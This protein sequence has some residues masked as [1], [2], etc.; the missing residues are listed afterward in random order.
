[1][2][3][4]NQSAPIL[5]Q[6]S[7]YVGDLN[8][9]V[10][11]SSLYTLFS[12]IGSVLSAR[13]C[14]DLATRNSL[15]YGYV[16]FEDPKDAERA[17]EDLNY[18]IYH[19]R[20]IRIMWSQRDPSLR[21]SG[22]GNIF[23]KNLDKSIEQKELYDT[24]SYFG[25]ILSC[26]IA[27]DEHG[28]SKGYGF[29]HFEKEECAERAI[30]KINGMLIRDRVVFVGKF[31]PSCERKSA[32]GKL[33]FNNVY[34]KNFPPDTTDEKLKEMFS[35]F[36]EIKSCC[37]EKDAEGK[38]KGFGF[39]CFLNPDHAEQ[40]VK[41]MHGKELAGRTLY[42]NRAQ[43]KEERQ[44]ELKQRLE[45][46]RLERQSKY[47]PGVNLYVKNLDDTI[48]DERLKEA[49]CHYG[50]ITSAKVMTDPNGRS[51]GFG[52]VCFTQPE[53]AA[54][55]VT[56]MNAALVGTKPLYVALAQRKEDRRAKLIA[57]HHQR[58]TQYR[59]NPAQMLPAA[60]AHAATPSYF[61]PNA[62]PQAQRYYHPTSAVLNSQPRWNRAAAMSGGMP[63]QLGGGMQARPSIPG[64]YLGAP[65]PAAGMTANQLAA[66][67]QLRSPAAVG[68]P[69]VPSGMPAGPHIP[70]SAMMN[71]AMNQR[72][73]AARPGAPMQ[74]VM[75]PPA[76]GFPQ[77]P[78]MASVVAANPNANLR[79]VGQQVPRTM[80]QPGMGQIT[81]AAGNVRFNQTARNVT[82]QSA[83]TPGSN[84]PSALAPLGD[85]N[86]LT[87][88]ALA[89]LS[90][91]DQK[92]T[93]GERL[94]PLVQE[95]Y[96]T[97]A[98]KLTGMMLG[99]DNAEV[100][101][102]LESKE[103]LRAKLDEGISVLKSSRN[104][105]PDLIEEANVSSD[106]AAM[107]TTQ[108]GQNGD[109][110]TEA[111]KADMKGQ[112]VVSNGLKTET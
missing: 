98:Q 30:E 91:E 85:Q 41:T 86:P 77:R 47:V 109:G 19:G 10:A 99:M 3:V 74:H 39:V 50:S 112:N 79:P 104:L 101:N 26:K 93:L 45:K 62:F 15:G 40:A 90:E 80:M 42:A 84:M 16:N 33:R 72:Q 58:M 29:V 105:P 95:I 17:L 76:T 52:F 83:P 110:S 25:R 106:A 27:M 43:R 70:G 18:E 75:A 4:A 51:K 21:K 37:V 92:R 107:G 9:Q 20:P 103:S 102:L 100:I 87:I 1:M 7:L 8:P 48:D 23:I 2:A 88:S 69:M 65:N 36:G 59:S 78:S 67:A 22:K 49:F 96:P 97:L 5:P 60:A 34:V 24:F 28:H 13:I 35:E 64:H 53:Q 55:A 81:G 32:S 12:R 94:F 68:R 71:P 108:P 11:E 111:L 61:P 46:Q 38:S 6:T 89:Q 14:R 56:E 57:E 54:R 63:A 44:E 73:A 66:M 31:I 82:T